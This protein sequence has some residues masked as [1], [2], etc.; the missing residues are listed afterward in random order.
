MTA[1]HV[2]ELTHGG[3]KGGAGRGTKQLLIE[4]TDQPG[5][6][7]QEVTARRATELIQ[8]GTNGGAWTATE[9]TLVTNRGKSDKA[10]V[11]P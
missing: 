11:H 9:L 1:C 7:E 3:T 6:M 5:D 10:T 8:C 2:K 4:G